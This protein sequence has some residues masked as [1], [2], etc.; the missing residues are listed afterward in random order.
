MLR[1]VVLLVLDK[2]AVDANAAA[3]AAYYA[4]CYSQLGAQPQST[5]T[6][7][8]VQQQPQQSSAYAAVLPRTTIT[9]QP[10]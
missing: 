7:A 1:G 10:C 6:A 3:W 9:P 5:V 2:Q 4:Q 8:A